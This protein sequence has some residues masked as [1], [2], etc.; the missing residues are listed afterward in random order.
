MY[1]YEKET[2]FETTWNKLL[3]DYKVEENAWLRLLYNLKE[4]WTLVT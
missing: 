1:E 4:K 3:F 2:S